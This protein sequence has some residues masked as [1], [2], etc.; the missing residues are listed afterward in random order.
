MLSAIDSSAGSSLIGRQSSS[1]HKAQPEFFLHKKR[2]GCAF[3]VP[4][5]IWPLVAHDQRLPDV[6]NAPPAARGQWHTGGCRGFSP[7]RFIPE[8]M[9]PTATTVR[10]QGC[11]RRRANHCHRL[12][13][14][15]SSWS[16]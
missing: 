9:I 15:T 3:F 8:R 4:G 2:S 10:A 14:S 12:L 5:A 7:S 1:K 13:C 11:A 6:L 16:C